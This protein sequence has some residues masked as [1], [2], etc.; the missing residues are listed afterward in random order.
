MQRLEEWK[1]TPDDRRILDKRSL[2]LGLAGKDTP[3]FG[4]T[5]RYKASSFKR[6]ADGPAS[7]IFRD[8]YT[9]EY[10]IAFQALLKI[11]YMILHTTNNVDGAIPPASAT[12]KF[13]KFKTEVAETL[14]LLEATLPAMFFDITLH[15]LIHLPE[16]IFRWNHVRN[17]WCFASERFIGVLKEYCNSRNNPHAGMVYGYSQTTFVRRTMSSAAADRINDRFQI[18][19]IV[20]T[21]R[22]AS[23]S[24]AAL[25]EMRGARPGTGQFQANVSWRNAIVAKQSY[26]ARVGSF[27]RQ[28]QW[29]LN[30]YAGQVVAR[31]QPSLPAYKAKVHRVLKGVQINGRPWKRG[32]HCM[33]KDD[34]RSSKY[35]VVQEFIRWVEKAQGRIAWCVKVSVHDILGEENRVL[36]VE[37]KSDRYVFIFWQQLQYYCSTNNDK[38]WTVAVRRWSTTDNE[39]FDA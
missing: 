35:G 13:R 36:R 9:G 29:D 37:K 17:Y 19:D 27:I 38:D 28:K 2:G 1:L 18:K 39:N 32:D 31:Q 7:L 8:V 6:L 26:V 22:S 21:M 4:K 16:C 25:V 30:R 23:I 33:W 5:F 24:F 12:T 11:L 3:L 10:K 20:P 14:V 15:V 34:D